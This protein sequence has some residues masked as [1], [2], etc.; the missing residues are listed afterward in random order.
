MLLCI[1]LSAHLQNRQL[2]WFCFLLHNAFNS[3]G[4][5]LAL[6]LG[7]IWAKPLAIAFMLFFHVLLCLF[8]SLWP[9]FDTA[10]LEYLQRNL[11]IAFLCHRLLLLLY[12]GNK[13]HSC[14]SWNLFCPKGFHPQPA[15]PLPWPHDCSA[16]CTSH[17]PLGLAE[18][19]V[20]HAS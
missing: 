10:F 9:A 16:S 12:P 5:I 20:N 3:P 4:V 7:S 17:F 13:A 8:L 11:A 19:Q 1:P 14:L 18:A 6:T 2:N 15:S